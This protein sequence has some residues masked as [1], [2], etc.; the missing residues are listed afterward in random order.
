MTMEG[1]KAYIFDLDGT[2][3]DTLDDLADAVNFSM[4]E[5]GFPERTRDEVR[6]FVG[7]GM[8]LLVKRSAP[9]DSGEDILEKAFIDFRD[10]YSVHYMDKTKPYPEIESVLK[11]LKAQG[12]SL[13]VISNKADYAVKLLMDR[14]FPGIFET[15]LGEREGIRRKPAPDSLLAVM[16]EL[17]LAKAQCVY[18]GDS[19]TDIE[20][21]KNAGI[22]SVSV[23]W[24]FRTEA[25]LK[26]SGAEEIVDTPVGLLGI[27]ARAE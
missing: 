24:G 15:V 3:L 21:A 23:S 14:F 5:N 17:G 20:T 2:L 7:D 25:F 22:G 9:K 13:C 1:Y 27:K 10:Y 19:D 6:S 16:D 26:K 11:E 12:K 4:R 18:I 8:R